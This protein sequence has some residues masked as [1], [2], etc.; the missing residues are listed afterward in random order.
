MAQAASTVDTLNGLFKESYAS[1]IRDLVP[2][3]VKLLNMIS[4]NSSDKA[5]GNLYHAPVTLGL[6]HGVT[7]GGADGNVFLLNAAARS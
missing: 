6:E 7:Y 2:E 5:P 4:F 1:K 3:G